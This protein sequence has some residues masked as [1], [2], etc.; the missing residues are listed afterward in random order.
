MCYKYARLHGYYRD[1]ADLAVV[2]A[3]YNVLSI[4]GVGQGGH[5][6]EVTLLLENVRLTLPLPHQQLAHPYTQTH[7]HT[8][9]H[10]Y[11]HRGETLAQTHE[12]H[13][14]IYCTDMHKHTSIHKTHANTD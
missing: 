4:R 9:T 3:G 7:T 14:C 6:V 10:T 8:H 13:I 1:R 5:V 2:A 12:T 11:T